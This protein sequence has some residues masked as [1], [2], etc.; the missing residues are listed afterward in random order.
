MGS[1]SRPYLSPEV[2]PPGLGRRGDTW[3]REDWSLGTHIPIKRDLMD[4]TRQMRSRCPHP[5]SVNKQSGRKDRPV[6]EVYVAPDQSDWPAQIQTETQCRW[7]SGFSEGSLRSDKRPE[8]PNTSCPT[9]G[10]REWC[11]IDECSPVTGRSGKGLSSGNKMGSDLT[12]TDH[13]S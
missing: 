9:Y 7:L 10:R 1:L 2:L 8:M 5:V 12:R 4:H 11:G 13:N 3:N 6:L